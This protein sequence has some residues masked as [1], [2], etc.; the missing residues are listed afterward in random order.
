MQGFNPR[1]FFSTSCFFENRWHCNGS[2][3]ILFLSIICFYSSAVDLASTG[4]CHES[5]AFYVM[6]KPRCLM[7]LGKLS[8]LASSQQTGT[9]H[10]PFWCNISCQHLIRN[11]LHPAVPT[12]Q[13]PQT[14]TQQ[15]WQCERSH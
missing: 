10:P 5:W 8:P 11:N 2:A 7:P 12:Q 15:N 3:Y 6:N 1:L 13:S 14:L 4:K 9:L